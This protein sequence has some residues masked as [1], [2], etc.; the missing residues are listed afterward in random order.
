MEKRG[1]FP[2]RF[3]ISHTKVAWDWAEVDA[4]IATKKALDEKV[5]APSGRQ[6]RAKRK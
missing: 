2:K 6:K 1:E 5:P 3:A 4:W